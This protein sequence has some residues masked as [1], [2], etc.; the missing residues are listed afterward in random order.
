MTIRIARKAPGRGKGAKC[1]TP[2]RKLRGAPKCTRLVPVLTRTVDAQPGA[3]ELK[4]DRRLKIGRYKVSA[5]ARDMAGNA[6]Q[7]KGASVKV[8]KRI[9]RHKR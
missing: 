4:L 1:V 8:A 5:A 2:S 3:N 9:K 7:V 6:A